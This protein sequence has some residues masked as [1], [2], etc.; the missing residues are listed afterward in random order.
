M[1]AS[2]AAICLLQAPTLGAG[3]L[4]LSNVRFTYGILGPTRTEAKIRPGDSVFLSFDI[5]GIGVDDAGKASYTTAVEVLD[6]KG[7]VLFK[8]APRKLQEF[9]PLGGDSLPAFAHIDLGAD[10]PAGEYTMK[11]IVTDTSNN[12]SAPVSVKFEVLGKAFDVVRI[13]ITGDGDGVVPVGAFCV[14]QPF[15]I[16]GAV[17]GFGRA[18]QGAKQPKVKL[19][20]RVLDESGKAIVA[21]P[22]TGM[23]DKDVDAKAPSLPIR[24]FVPL[25]RAG[26]Y[27]IELAATDEVKNA[28]VSKKFPITVTPIK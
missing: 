3:D 10:S 28:T 4:S 22:F 6:S 27:T 12:K 19:N 18:A 1:L 26:Q 8:Q 2:L 11:V 9:L 15:W 5:Q 7:S 24:F 20:L 13:G 14:G 23:I 17:V 21:K 25:N 16:H